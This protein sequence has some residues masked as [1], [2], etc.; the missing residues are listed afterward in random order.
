MALVEE[1]VHWNK[2]ETMKCLSVLKLLCHALAVVK[3]C[4]TSVYGNWKIL[5]VLCHYQVFKIIPMKM[6]LNE[7]MIGKPGSKVPS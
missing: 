7:D 6:L 1:N 3:S 5:S 4:F 2:T